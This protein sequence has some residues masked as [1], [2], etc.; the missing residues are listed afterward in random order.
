ML[1]VRIDC[2]VHMCGQTWIG[3]K[4]DENYG[5]ND[6]SIRGKRYFQT[7]P[8]CGGFVLP[9]AVNVGTTT[10]THSCVCHCDV[11]ESE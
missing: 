2:G 1:R 11:V 4:F 8:R 6:G 9:Q 10:T 7:E 5:K 3:V